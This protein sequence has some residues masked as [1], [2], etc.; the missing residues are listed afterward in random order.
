MPTALITGASSGI[1]AAT[2]REL[3]ARGY[4]VGLLGRRALPLSAVADQLPDPDVG[5]HVTI[6]CDVSDPSSVDVAVDQVVLANGVPDVL[7]TAAGACLPASLPDTTPDVW[8][9]T[10]AVNLTGSFLV[11]RAVA[12][13]MAVSGPPGQQG[14]FVLVGSEQ[15]LIGVP[16]YSAYAA[17]KSALVGLTRAL[18]A[19]LAPKIRVNLLCPGPVDTP[20]LE[21]E[22]ELSGNAAA[23]R[24]AELRRVP[25]RRIASAEETAK[26]AVWLLLDAPY[27]TGSILNLDGGTTGAFM[28]ALS[29]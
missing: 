29:D 7:V 14:S 21:A 15:S 9:E 5:H 11:A 25:L 8:N 26:A 10:L 2:A 4:A 6:V 28:A 24:A 19:E 16:K 17:S 20:M 22:F 23:A 13:A 18:A 1:G 3:A 27:A 12:L